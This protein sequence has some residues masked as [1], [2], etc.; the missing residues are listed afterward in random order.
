MEVPRKGR[1]YSR[2]T[3]EDSQSTGDLADASFSD[4]IRLRREQLGLTLRDLEQRTGIGNSTLSRWERGTR[5]PETVEGIA[6][7]AVALEVDPVYLHGKTG[8]SM[9]VVLPEVRPYLYAKYG[10]RVSAK[11]LSKIADRVEQMLERSGVQLDVGTE[12]W[13]GGER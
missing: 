9:S 10:D 12:S 6:D 11:R 1:D 7:L 4:F 3:V 8:R 13:R 2:G 5:Q